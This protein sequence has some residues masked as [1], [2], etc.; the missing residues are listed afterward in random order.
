LSS[1]NEPRNVFRY[2]EQDARSWA[3]PEEAEVFVFPRYNWWNNILRIRSLD[4]ASRTITLAGD[5]SYP[6]RPT[7]RYYVQNVFEELDAPGEWYLDARTG[8]LYLWP[9]EDAGTANL[10]VYAPVIR[11]ILELEPGTAHVTFRGF[12]FEVSEGTAIVLNQAVACLIAG[13][14]IRNA[15]DY[16]GSGVTVNGGKDNGVVGNDIYDIGS[17][18]VAISG[19]DR[20]TLTPAGNYAE[21][22]YIHHVGVYYKQGVGISLQGV[23]NRAAHNLIHDT[24]RMGIMFSGNNLIIEYNHI[25][26]VNLETADTGA[27]YT[28]GRDWLSSRG[29]VIRYN[30]F[31]DILGYGQEN[32]KW[33]SPHYAW[34]IYLDDNAGGIDVIGNIVVRAIRGLI[35]LHNGRDNRI[36]NNIFVDGKLQQVEYTGWTR[37]HSYW[38]THLPTM[39]RGYESV[40]SR[41]EWQGMRNMDVHPSEAVL[42]D[43]TIMSGNEFRRNIVYYTDPE[44][45]LFTLA[46]VNYAHNHWSDNLYWHAGLPVE[47]LKSKN[48][49]DVVEWQEW[50]AGERDQGSVVADPRFVDPEHDDFRLQPDSPAFALGFQPIPVERIGPYQ[51]ELRASWPIVEVEGAREKPLVSEQD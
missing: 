29:T 43:G 25:R 11:T 13:N 51:D 28:G 16:Q 15:G 1:P 23:G 19:G 36:E 44:S 50:R 6:I 35:H 40:Q 7:D 48:R 20:I 27:I 21:N 12:T 32:G 8:T 18:G 33:V 37:T 47:S 42:P 10:T 45:K 49:H 4:R 3:H 34:G 22:N 31:H 5:A 24:P 9:P 41:P 17:H 14:V 26:H 46:S 39:I 2:K 38:T 30:Y